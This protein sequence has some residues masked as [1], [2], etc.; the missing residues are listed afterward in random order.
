MFKLNHTGELTVLYA[1][2]DEADGGIPYAGVIRDEAGNLYGTTWRRMALMASEWCSSWIRRQ[3]DRAVR[4]HRGSGRGISR[5]QID[6][7]RGGQS[8][9]HYLRRGDLSGVPQ[10]TGCG[11]VFKLDT[12]GKETVLYSFTGGADGAYPQRR[13]DP[14]R[15]GNLYGTTDDGGGL[16]C[17][18]PNGCGVVFKLD[19]DWQGDRAV[20]PSRGERTALYPSAI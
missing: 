4:L 7:G 8:L 2:T 10:P 18:A 1:F 6:P 3:G 20:Q 15:G 16:N 13:S 12:T 5:R 19:T 9:R 14:G 17:Y 11:V